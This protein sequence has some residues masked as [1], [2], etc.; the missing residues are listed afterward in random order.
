MVDR[1]QR[2]DV[3]VHLRDNHQWSELIKCSFLQASL[4][5][6]ASKWFDGA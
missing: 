6:D 3:G 4:K 1:V 2:P 5:R